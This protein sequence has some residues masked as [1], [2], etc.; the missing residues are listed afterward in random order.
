MKVPV[1][2]I[3]IITHVEGENVQIFK[4]LKLTMD[5]YVLQSVFYLIDMHVA[6]KTF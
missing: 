1:N 4:Y 5:I 6:E 3:Q 2:N